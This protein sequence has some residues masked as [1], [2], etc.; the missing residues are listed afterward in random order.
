MLS[1]ILGLLFFCVIGALI[2]FGAFR[3]NRLVAWENHAVN[4]AAEAV[5]RYRESLELEDAVLRAAEAE[6]SAVPLSQPAPQS[7]S[8]RR[9]SPPDRGSGRAA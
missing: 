3:A 8:A 6:A 2:V 1:S 9:A 7:A 5:G 4:A